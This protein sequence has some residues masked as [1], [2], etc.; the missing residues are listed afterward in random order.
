MTNYKKI[1]LT[2]I[3]ASCTGLAFAGD[4]IPL[5]YNGKQILVVQILPQT[6]DYCIEL[7]DGT[8]EH[9]DLAIYY[10]QLVIF[11]MPIFNYGK[12]E[13]VLFAPIEGRE[14]DYLYSEL[15]P[16]DMDYIA[17][18]TGERVPLQPEL[19]FWDKW[20]G[21]LA[22][23]TFLSFIALLICKGPKLLKK[24]RSRLYL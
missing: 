20:G 12:A 15:S 14:Y 4:N 9:A 13:Y 2:I 11:G 16:D 23:L 19:P 3:L 17:Y 7:D 5:F 24:H 10:D 8:K 18:D 21:K 1:I 6:D 22:M